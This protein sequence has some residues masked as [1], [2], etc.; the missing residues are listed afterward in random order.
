MRKIG[1]ALI[2][3]GA[4][5]TAQV[6]AA[7]PESKDSLSRLASLYFASNARVVLVGDGYVDLL[8]EPQIHGIYDRPNPHREPTNAAEM[9]RYLNDNGQDL[10]L[11]TSMDSQKQVRFR[12]R[13]EVSPER[14]RIRF[15]VK[16]SEDRPEFKKLLSTEKEVRFVS[17]AYS[18][19]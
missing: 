16:Y 9:V 11:L 5:F 19:K 8:V 13:A 7:M 4:L 17:L 12:G 14:D 6:Q 15:T 1:T 18:A 2:L 3:A 10:I